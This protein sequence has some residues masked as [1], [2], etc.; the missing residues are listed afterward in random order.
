MESMS[1]AQTAQIGK[2]SFPPSADDSSFVP[3]EAVNFLERKLWQ[4]TASVI[5]IGMASR[6]L[7]P[8]LG[9]KGV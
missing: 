8:L 5:F 9:L 7:G 3:S 4:K 6:M 2:V 1:Q